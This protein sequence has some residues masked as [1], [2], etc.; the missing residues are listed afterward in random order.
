MTLIT[1]TGITLCFAG[2]LCYGENLNGKLIDASCYQNSSANQASS[3]PDHSSRKLDKECAPT[4]ATKDFAVQTSNKKVYKLDSS[5]NAKAAD[6]MKSGSI[7]PDNDGDVHV[8]VAGSTQG[9]TIKV[10][11][12]EGKGEH[13]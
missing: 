6:A 2:L 11:S 3:P 13:R 12:I 4:A 9:S 5:G 10:D 7:K 1:K 8:S